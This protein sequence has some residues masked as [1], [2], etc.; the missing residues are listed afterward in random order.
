MFWYKPDNSGKA[1]ADSL[2]TQCICEQVQYVRDSAI[3]IKKS[4]GTLSP[5]ST[6][7]DM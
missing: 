5:L 4:V 2:C 7:V 3:V 1:A 6:L